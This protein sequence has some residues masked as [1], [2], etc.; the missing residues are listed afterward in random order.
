MVI[1]LRIGQ[2]AG[3]LPKSVTAGYGRLSTTERVWVNDEGRP[4]LSWLKIQ[5]SPIVKAFGIAKTVLLVNMIMDIYK[6]CF[7]RIYIL[8]PV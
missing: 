2:S 7:N 5:S 3:L 6:G 4:I 8:V 1:R